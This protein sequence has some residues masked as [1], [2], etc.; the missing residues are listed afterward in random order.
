MNFDDSDIL[1]YY[2]L[3]CSWDRFYLTK[4]RK[5]YRIVQKR[6][7]FPWACSVPIQQNINLHLLCCSD[8]LLNFL[9]TM[10]LCKDLYSPRLAVYQSSKIWIYIYF[11]AQIFYYILC[12]FYGV[13]QKKSI[14]PHGLQYTN[15]AK[16]E[17]YLFCCSYLLLN[18]VNTTESYKEELYALRLA[19]TNPTKFECTFTL[20]HRSHLLNFVNT[21]ESCKE[22][23]FIPCGLQCTNNVIIPHLLTLCCCVAAGI[24]PNK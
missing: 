6:A 14:I 12:K 22:L 1:I 4:Y 9:N 3:C 11:A 5:C 17:Y 2:F 21:T 23:I 24:R 8:L 18:F 10:E 13:G 16:F 20:L 15:R 7:V 19:V